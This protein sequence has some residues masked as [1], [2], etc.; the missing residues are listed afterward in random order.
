MKEGSVAAP[1]GSSSYAGY[2]IASAASRS[3]VRSRRLEP[4]PQS[5]ETGREVGFAELLG[6]QHPR[7][8]CR[9]VN[10]EGRE[11]TEARR[12][13]CKAEAR[14]DGFRSRYTAV[15]FEAEYTA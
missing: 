7:P 9:R 6:I 1:R 3:D 15:D 8:H 14:D 5:N 13:V 10:D 12:S 11:R 4:D 2:Q